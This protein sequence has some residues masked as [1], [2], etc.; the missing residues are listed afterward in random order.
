[1]EKGAP[2]QD[3]DS[4][5]I[6]LG[7]G[8]LQSRNWALFMQSQGSGV[9]HG[10]GD[11]WCALAA[12][13]S[14]LGIRFLYVPYGP[15]AE[16][17]EALDQAVIALR[18]AA[19]SE[20][21]AFIRME[22]TGEVTNEQ[23]R[24]LGAREVSEFQPRRT[25]VLSLTE[26]E[27]TLRGAIS[28]S[29]RNLINT[30]EKRGVTFVKG[31]IN[32]LEMFLSLL[33]KTSARAGITVY[34]DNYYRQLLSVFG[35]QASLYFAEV[36]GQVVAGAISLDFGN[37][38]YYAHAAS[39]YDLNRRHK[40]AVPL[41]WHL[42]TEAK[43]SGMTVFDFWGIAPN[44]DPAHKKAG[45]TQLKLSFGSIILERIGTWELSISPLAYF[46]YRSAKKLITRSS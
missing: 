28:Q 30:A 7:G 5:V 34:S 15:Y 43:A 9:L 22:P 12:V 37:T 10:S 33:H 31:G 32:D 8:V 45:I 3:W 4:R 40:A 38:R 13:R 44:D 21:C 29:N 2:S 17:S 19:L 24:N 41:L 23:M 14:K 6:S 36:E 16:S 46:V 39:D 35:E 18:L 1:M 42:V 27:E 20:K 11:G 26:P 25:A